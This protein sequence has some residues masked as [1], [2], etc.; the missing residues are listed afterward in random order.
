MT[1]KH[2]DQ[3][4]RSRLGRCVVLLVGCGPL[5]LAGC[6]GDQSMLA[7]ASKQSHDIEVLW[8]WM[9]GAAV[10]V[11]FGAVALLGMAWFRRG[12][13]GLPLFGERESVPQAMVIGFGVVI[14][15][16]TLVVLF[17]VSDVYMVG[18]TSPPNPRSTAMTIDVIGHQWWWEIRY[19]AT[20]AVTANEI[21]IPVDTRVNIV[22]TT[23]D[24]IHSLWVPP[25]NRKI[26]MIPGYR[27]RLLF[28]ADKLGV[29][30]GQCAQFCGL[31]HAHMA[32][33]VFV[34]TPVAFRAWLQNM[35]KPADQ[36]VTALQRAGEHVFMTSSC[37][38]CHTIGGTSA[39][40]TVG[41]N[42]THLATRTSL[43]A[44]TIA[45]TP[46]ELAAWIR[47]PQAIKPGDRMPD[48]GLSR[49]AI[50][51]LVAYLDGLH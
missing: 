50:T 28:D 5:L 19:P 37:A 34:Q 40:G 27:N 48:L 7:P 43:A 4:H 44:D 51:A 3:R 25:I 38:S 10:V 16:V 31:Q 26:D 17:G 2:R 33:K 11:F 41:P 39:Q 6:G 1:R 21:H 30:R 24:V 42:L 23:A 29:Y 20:G 12:T 22:A 9:L 46:S 35:T 13:R 15:V 49:T 32:L 18:Q 14:P 36:P 8:W 45:N 47:N